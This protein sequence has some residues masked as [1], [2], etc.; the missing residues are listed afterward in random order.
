MFS[1]SSDAHTE[2]PE[3]KKPSEKEVILALLES[4][5]SGKGINL[6]DLR[7]LR[8]QPICQCGP[9]EKQ[10]YINPEILIRKSVIRPYEASYSGKGGKKKNYGKGGYD[11]HNNYDD[12]YNK[13]G[14][15]KSQHNK[16]RGYKQHGSTDYH[17]KSHGGDRGH[18]NR[19]GEDAKGFV[20]NQI[21]EAVLTMKTEATKWKGIIVNEDKTMIEKQIKGLLNKI[22]PDNI[23]KLKGEISDVL[24]K[25][26]TE[27]DRKKF[28]KI[29]FKKATHEEKYC[30]MYTSLIKF[31][32]EQEFNKINDN[33][34]TPTEVGVSKIKKAKESQIKKELVEECRTVVYEFFEEMKF[35]A[36]TE[37]DLEDFKYR[38]KKRLFGNLNFIAELY[39]KKLIGTNIPILVFKLLLG[40]GDGN[41]NKNDFT[42]E[43]ACTMLARVGSKLDKKDKVDGDSPK[44]KKDGSKSSA[45]KYQE[46]FELVLK[47]LEDL[48]VDETV[49]SRIRVII[50]NTLERRNNGWIA[51]II[52]EGPKT[53]K[54][55]YKEHMASLY[56]EPEPVVKKSKPSVKKTY[57]KGGV[58]DNLSLEKIESTNSQASEF[59]DTYGIPKPVEKDRSPRELEHMDHEAVKDRFIGNF[60]EWLASSE[61]EFDMFSKSDNKCSP[62]KIVEFLLDKLY[63]K[64]EAEVTRFSEYFFGLYHKHLF[65]KK[66][67]EKGL[68]SFFV[69]IPDIEADFPHLPSLFSELLYFIFV[70]KNIADFK[71][72]DIKLVGDNGKHLDYNLI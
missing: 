14:N 39:K 31:L 62:D 46:S 20:R 51:T 36:V 29:M 11:R 4:M 67:I 34:A 38:Y 8:Y 23:K 5:R 15:R 2:D 70:E 22:T 60:V 12:N 21:S 18:G 33:D 64:P 72:V 45:E 1:A 63:D 13:G 55:M 28:I 6:E 66:D 44:K 47:T 52:D 69:T 3:S 53:K 42:I 30:A 37:L 17:Q 65:D 41:K 50:K 58:F 56:G 27:E 7:N 71:R 19:G 24:A 43:G 26:E 54:Q 10:V 35:E 16:P 48:Q 9:N 57:S 49:D 68:T 32:G 25:C 59:D 61:F 40:L